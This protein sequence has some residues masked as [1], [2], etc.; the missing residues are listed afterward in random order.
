[1]DFS[2]EAI[3]AALARV[4][5]SSVSRQGLKWG[6]VDATR[7]G[8]D[9]DSKTR[10]EVVQVCSNLKNGEGQLTSSQGVGAGGDDHDQD[11]DDLSLGPSSVDVVLDKGLLDAL[12]LSPPGTSSSSVVVQGSQ[13]QQGAKTT[14]ATPSSQHLKTPSSS[15]SPNARLGALSESMF[16]VLRTGGVWV[17]WSLSAPAVVKA[18]LNI[19]DDAAA[20]DTLR[21]SSH[22]EQG[23]N[24]DT[25]P[26]AGSEKEFLDWKIT[27]LRIPNAYLYFFRKQKRRKLSHSK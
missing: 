21:S 19:Q 17:V 18:S 23:G 14:A 2:S 10:E 25:T 11:Q 22:S 7:L 20:A 5:R 27:V 9:S 12:L 26:I 13:Q 1:M 24:R 16:R 8:E 3:S 6:V 15:F 4:S